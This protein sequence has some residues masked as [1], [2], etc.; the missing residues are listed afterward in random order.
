VTFAPSTTESI[1]RGLGFAPEDIRRNAR[2]FPGTE[3]RFDTLRIGDG[4]F[5]YHRKRE[6][7]AM[8]DRIGAPGSRVSRREFVAATGGLGAT[9]LAGCTAK[10]EE[11][12]VNR[13]NTTTTNRNF[14]N[15]TDS[16]SAPS[17]VAQAI[18]V[19]SRPPARL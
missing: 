9:A 19:V 1:R 15:K 3:N 2:S 7:V 10:F 4:G 18:V 6:G 12:G 17:A 11:G 13:S 5:K 14:P 8:T 16:S